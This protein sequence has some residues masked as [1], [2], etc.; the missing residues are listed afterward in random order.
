MSGLFGGGSAKTD[1][2][3][4]T[5]A[6]QGLKNTFNWALPFAQSVGTAGQNII[7]TGLSDLSTAGGYFKNILS[8]NRPAVLQAVAP[9]VSMVRSQ[10]DAQKR[11]LAASGTA[12]GGG[13]SASSQQRESNVM[14]EVDKLLFGVRPEAAKGVAGVGEAEAKIGLGET[15]TGLSAGQ[16]ASGTAAELGSL[17]TAARQTDLQQQNLLGAGA[18]DLAFGLLFS[19]M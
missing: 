13:V 17:G 19:G 12:R 5:T 16:L 15:A 10:S 9:E 2:G 18:A 4:Q 3:W 6:A 11:Q 7:S 8:G 14:S 1:R